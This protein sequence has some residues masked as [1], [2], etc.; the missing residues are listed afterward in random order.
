M[1]SIQKIEEKKAT[2]FLQMISKN[3]LFFNFFINFSYI[4]K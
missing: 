2:G 4:Y 3:P 1:K